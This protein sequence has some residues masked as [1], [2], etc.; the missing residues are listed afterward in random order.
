MADNLP[1]SS[2]DVTESGSLN[3][4]EPSGPHMHVMGL[5]Y[6]YIYGGAEE[7]HDKPLSGQPVSKRRFDPHVYL[8][9]SIPF[10]HFTNQLNICRYAQPVSWFH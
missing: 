6:L 2:V 4:P 8:S 1:P 7:I 9:P 5:L 3:L 10:Y